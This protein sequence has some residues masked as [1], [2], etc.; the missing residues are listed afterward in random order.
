MSE[1][2]KAKKYEYLLSHFQ[3]ILDASSHDG[4]YNK[5]FCDCLELVIDYMKN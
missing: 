3:G 4:D 5:G 1:T 2:E